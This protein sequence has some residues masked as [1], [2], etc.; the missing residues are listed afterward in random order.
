MRREFAS[1]SGPCNAHHVRQ[2]FGRLGVVA[3]LVLTLVLFARPAGAQQAADEPAYRLKLDFDVPLVLIAGATASGFFFLPELPGAT[4]APNCDRKHINRFDRW[5]AGNYDPSWARVGDIA[6]VATLAMPLIVVAV[7]EGVARG[8]NDDLV[9]AEAALVTSAAQIS[10]SFAVARPRP[11]V[12]SDRAPLDERTDANA[13]RSFF[14]GHVANTMA[15]SVAA[16]RTLQR[17]GRPALGW[18]TFGAGLAGTGLVGASRVLS[19][20]HF[21][22]DVLVGAALGAG[23]GLALPALHERPFR[24]EPIAS[25]GYT[26]LLVTGAL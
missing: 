5:A 21:P 24:I 7:D 10:I 1:W 16:L 23:V 19:G 9:I 26:G 25:E 12:Y 2:R 8:L 15:A 4:C 20:S 14:S 6:T 11:R 3:G 17:V 22:S 13:A 18:T